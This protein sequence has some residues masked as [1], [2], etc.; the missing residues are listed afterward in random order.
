MYIVQYTYMYVHC[1][2]MSGPVEHFWIRSKTKALKSS[3][4]W[5]TL[6][7]WKT[8]FTC[9]NYWLRET[10]RNKCAWVWW[11]LKFTATFGNTCRSLSCY[12]FLSW[13]WNVFFCLLLERTS[14][15]RV[16]A[17]VCVDRQ[18]DPWCEPYLHKFYACCW[19]VQSSQCY[20]CMHTYRYRSSL[21]YIE[22]CTVATPQ[23]YWLRNYGNL[24]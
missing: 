24:R 17:R 13:R 1:V 12:I 14:F 6:S 2:C 4:L 5:A 7:S 10:G 19:C 15:S 22:A 8:H 16:A 20:E 23:L 21:Q 11:A 3:E 18:D 9:K